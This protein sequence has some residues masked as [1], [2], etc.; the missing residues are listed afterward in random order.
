[1]ANTI[2]LY[3]ILVG[4]SPYPPT[5]GG[6]WTNLTGSG[7]AAPLT[8]NASIDF[9]AQTFGFYEYEYAIANGNCN[10]V[11]TVGVDWQAHT[12]AAND[13]C[14]TARVIPCPYT[15]DP[16]TLEEQTNETSCPGPKF[17]MNA[18]GV[19]AIWGAGPF[20]GDAWFK[21]T[22]NPALS[23]GLMPTDLIVTIDG[24]AYGSS[25]IHQPM[26]ALY[27]NC[28][29]NVCSDVGAVQDV[30]CTW[31]GSFNTLFTLSIRVSS[32]SNTA[33]LFDVTLRLI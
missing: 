3:D 18:I 19:P 7:P 29:M 33:G 2:V 1:M 13:N 16:M 20:D 32:A 21:V 8:Y 15:T 6:V 23:G 12:I 22:Y 31:G 5:V 17:T 28:A 14:N 10:S 24:G 26:L 11:A 30:W 25:G 9:S 4:S 27:N